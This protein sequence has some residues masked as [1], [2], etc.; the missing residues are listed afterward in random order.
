MA[1]SHRENYLHTAN[2]TGGEWIPARIVFSDA[3]WDQLRHDLEDVLIH[4]PRYFPNFQKGQRDYDNYEFRAQ[5]RAGEDFADNYGCVWHGE[6]NGIVGIVEGHPLEDWDALEDFQMP[7]PETQ[8]PLGP[9]DWDTVREQMRLRTERGELRMA[10]TE[11]GFLFL[12]LYYLRGFENLMVDMA[13]EEPR[14][15]RLI[16]M[17]TQY[18]EY[19]VRRYLDMGI[20][21]YG[22][23]E[24][25]GAQTASVMGPRMFDR[26][27]AP[28]YRRIIDPCHE[29]GVHVHNHSDGYV[30]DIIDRLIDVGMTICNIQDLVNGVDDI[31]RELKGRVCVDLDVDRQSVVPYGTPREIRDLIEYEVRTLGSPQ[32]GLMMTCGVY[33]PTP[34]E[35]V[36]AVLCAMEEFERYWW[37]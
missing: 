16:E 18:T 34:P 37:A 1:L 21:V 28:A 4:H 33:P 13:T 12:R 32:G 27:I 20:D 19:Q 2:L 17:I 9:V 5:A 31:A 15:D 30:M 14:L 7:D 29:R 3:S 23:A 6:V 25:L 11:H 8:L 24:D 10:G 35:N 22:V 36:D 26:W